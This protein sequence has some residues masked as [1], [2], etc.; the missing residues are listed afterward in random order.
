MNEENDVLQINIPKKIKVGYNKREDTYTGKLAYVIYYDNK[1]KLR[2]EAS[3]E[4]WRDKKLG[5][6]DFDNIPTSGFVLNKKVGDYKSDWNHRMAHIRVYDPRGFEFEIGVENLLFIL[7]EC[8]STKGKGLEGDFVYA[9]DGKDLVLLPCESEDYKASQVFTNAQNQKVTKA[10]MKEGCV[11]INKK[12]QKVIYLGKHKWYEVDMY[13]RDDTLYK[14][15]DSGEKHIFAYADFDKKKNEWRYSSRYFADSG[16]T[17]LSSKV[18]DVIV[19]DYAD[20]YD[21]FKK[22]LEG[23]GIKE[24]ELVP[25]KTH[26]FSY[27]GEYQKFLLTVGN[28]NLMVNFRRDGYLQHYWGGHNDSNTYRMF[29]THKVIIE[30]N[31]IKYERVELDLR[32]ITLG[33]IKRLQFLEFSGKLHNNKNIKINFH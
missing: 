1:G 21:D 2:K 29:A 16:F 24:V 12:M 27:L 9:F 11:Y 3:W 23:A 15:K 30:G 14:Y 17:K 19:S 18:S 28:D 8:T 31:S 4:S 5:A 10:D 20:I 33:E 26:D 13:G 22:S 7:Q 6:D 32:S 25:S